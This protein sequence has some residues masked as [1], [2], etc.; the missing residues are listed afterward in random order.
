MQINLFLYNSALSNFQVN[1]V[2]AKKNSVTYL[3]NK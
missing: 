1:F 2:R 3:K